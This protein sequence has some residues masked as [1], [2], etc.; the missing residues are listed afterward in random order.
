VNQSV[1]TTAGTHGSPREKRTDGCRFHA[2]PN[3]E[4]STQNVT[5]TRVKK[6]LNKK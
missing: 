3:H 5:Q 2:P 1:V 4:S 6:G